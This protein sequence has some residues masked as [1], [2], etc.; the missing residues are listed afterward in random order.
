MKS[1]SFPV[2][3]LTLPLLVLIGCSI[4]TKAVALDSRV[5]S[6]SGTW[7]GSPVVVQMNWT[8]YSGLSTVTG[9]INY[10][11]SAVPFTGSNSRKGVLD[12]SFPSIPA[13]YRLQKLDT[14]VMTTW[15]GNFGNTVL[16][17]S[18]SSLAP[19]NITGGTGLPG[20]G[21]G[22]PGAGGMPPVFGGVPAGPGVPVGPK[23]MV[24]YT[25]S[26]GV[27]IRDSRR[28]GS[29]NLHG[30]LYQQSEI[31]LLQMGQPV[32]EDGKTWVQM[33]VSGWVPVNSS[34]KTYLANIGVHQW[35]VTWNRK[36]DYVAMRTG[37]SSANKLVCKLAYA[38]VV[39]A[40]RDEYQDGQRYIYATFQG[41]AVMKSKKTTFIRPIY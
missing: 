38:T 5:F 23:L 12:L 26:D 7:G 14:G 39:E 6:Y 34:S 29:D 16:S 8:D 27:N 36:N 17:F 31:P 4:S 3:Y 32:F 35:K 21:S 2:K 41:W 33:Q 10:Q 15:S 1:L 22:L 24:S 20:T 19:P 13:N 28:V 30:A 18:R 9:T 11:G 37:P 25:G 40:E